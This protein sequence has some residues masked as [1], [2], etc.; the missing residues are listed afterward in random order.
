MA[1]ERHIFGLQLRLLLIDLCPLVMLI[2]GEEH[3]GLTMK[4]NDLLD[5]KLPTKIER[6]HQ[7]AHRPFSAAEYFT[8]VFSIIFK[9][10][11]G[12]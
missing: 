4:V 9:Y 12:I 11:I 8:F 6:T 5:A 7:T 10:I 3:K 1:L 2:D